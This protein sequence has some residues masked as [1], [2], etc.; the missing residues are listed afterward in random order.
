MEVTKSPLHTPQCY[1]H[2]GTHLCNEMCHFLTLQGW[3][4]GTAQL[5]AQ[6]QTITLG[7]TN[8]SSAQVD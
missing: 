8:S 2:L 6:L 1:Q 3:H 4:H 7:A 5:F